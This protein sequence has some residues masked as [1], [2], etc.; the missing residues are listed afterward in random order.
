MLYCGVSGVFKAYLVN[1]HLPNKNRILRLYTSKQNF[2]LQVVNFSCLKILKYRFLFKFSFI[3]HLSSLRQNLQSNFLST[4]SLYFLF[5]C[6]KLH[7]KKMEE[8]MI[9]FTY[10]KRRINQN[11]FP[12]EMTFST[13]GCKSILYQFSY[14]RKCRIRHGCIIQGRITLHKQITFKFP[15]TPVQ[16]LVSNYLHSCSSFPA[17][18][19][20]SVL[21]QASS[22]QCWVLVSGVSK[23]SYTPLIPSTLVHRRCWILYMKSQASLA[24]PV[25]FHL[26]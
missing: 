3:F 26:Q 8:R 17:Q 10:I 2:T 24:L 22:D 5:H 13:N 14:I 1:I 16:L 7:Q 15:A 20:V 19:P 4:S 18:R 11:S 25:L 23:G 12:T 9:I 6:V 21:H